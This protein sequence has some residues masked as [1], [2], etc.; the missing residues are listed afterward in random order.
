METVMVEPK[1]TEI[2][3][4]PWNPDAMSVE[5]VSGL[6]T[7]LQVLECYVRN[8]SHA[9]KARANGDIERA[10]ELEAKCERIFERLPDWARW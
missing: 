7:G 6:A 8:K 5:E 4:I 2:E 1:T 3:P 9:M 10:T